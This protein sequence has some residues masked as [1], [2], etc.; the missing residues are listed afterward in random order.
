MSL[1]GRSAQISVSFTVAGAITYALMAVTKRTVTPAEFD[2]FSM[3]WGLAFFAAA[4][5]GS[6]VEQELTRATAV[7]LG[8]GDNPT[9]DIRRAACIACVIAASAAAV[10]TL[11]IALGVFGSGVASASI[12]VAFAT[13]ALGETALAVTRGALAGAGKVSAVSNLVLGQAMLRVVLVLA[14][15]FAGFGLLAICCAMSASNI[16]MILWFGAIRRLDNG[17]RAAPLELSTRGIR[18]LV[19]AAP[20]RA[21]FAVGLP[22]LAGVL[23]KNGQDGAVGDLLAALSLTSAPVFIAAAL[24][25]VLLPNF[26]GMI[27][28]GDTAEVRRVLRRTTATVVVVGIAATIGAL[29]WG[30]WALELLFGSSPTVSA[31]SLATMTAGAAM[32]FLANVLMPAVIARRAHRTVSVAWT[33]GALTMIAL[34][35]RQG[36]VDTRISQALLG[37]AFVVAACF[38][39][40]VRDAMLGSGHRRGVRS[41]RRGT[42]VTQRDL[43]SPEDAEGVGDHSPHGT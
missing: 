42:H 5:A 6:P 4:L 23:A 20:P 30:L 26:V 32:L 13:L 28:R 25:S 16:V 38:V 21:L 43:G 15:A 34:C 24:Q 35:F 27:E 1:R 33:V 37:G 39:V 36:S 12:V 29:W 3:F 9:V 8:R 7:H 18:R 40:A 2:V 11:L 19:A 17:P 41:A 14:A 10:G 31:A 22:A